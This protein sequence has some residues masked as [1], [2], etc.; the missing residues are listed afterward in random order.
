MTGRRFPILLWLYNDS[1]NNSHFKTFHT[2][3]FTLNYIRT[4]FYKLEHWSSITVTLLTFG[5]YNLQHNK[6]RVI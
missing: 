1:Q 3:T 2:L 6:I 5:L 4:L